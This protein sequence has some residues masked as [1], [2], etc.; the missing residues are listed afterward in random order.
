[1]LSGDG[2]HTTQESGRIS[3]CTSQH[4]SEKTLMKR[5]SK[6]S[7]TPPTKNS[8]MSNHRCGIQLELPRLATA[9]LVQQNNDLTSTDK[10]PIC[11]QSMQTQKLSEISALDRGLISNAK[12][13][14]GYWSDLCEAIS[15]QLFL[16]VVTDCVEKDLN[17]SSL[18]H[19][20]TVEASWFKKTL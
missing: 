19:N 18:W 4:R 15:S 2:I 12:G 6:T 20:K 11:N 9:E 8:M 1:M 10:L 17:Y 3:G 14:F 16:P 5:R 13:C 7:K